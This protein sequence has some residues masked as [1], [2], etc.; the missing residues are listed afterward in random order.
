LICQSVNGP[1]LPKVEVT[2]TTNSFVPS[3]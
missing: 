2:L 3:S 1:P